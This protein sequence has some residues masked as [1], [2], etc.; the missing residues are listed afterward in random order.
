MHVA[1]MWGLPLVM[2]VQDVRIAFDSMPHKLVKDA[3]LV[4][5]VSAHCTGLH[6]REVIGMQVLPYAGQT[7]LFPFGKGGKQG[8]VETPDEWKVLI[9]YLLE[10]VVML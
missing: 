7:P 6:M 1:V 2:S 8:G 10:P 9:D 4:R 5:G 3:L